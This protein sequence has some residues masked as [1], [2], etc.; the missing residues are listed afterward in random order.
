MDGY[1]AFIYYIREK[2]SLFQLEFLQLIRQH[3][4]LVSMSY[5]QV[6][7]IETTALNNQLR[8]LSKIWGAFDLRGLHT[9]SFLFTQSNFI[10]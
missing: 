4:F 10:A 5:F 9:D 8:R 3:L 1:T 2:K 6:N 7:F